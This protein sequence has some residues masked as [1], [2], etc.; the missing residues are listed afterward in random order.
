MNVT[1]VYSAAL[2]ACVDELS[3]PDIALNYT[4][5]NSLI[6]SELA[7]IGPHSTNSATTLMEVVL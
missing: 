7:E 2:T 1:K 3:E 5:S 6:L 4:K